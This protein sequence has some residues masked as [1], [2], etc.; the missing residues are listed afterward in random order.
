M[1][2]KNDGF[3]LIELMVVIALLGILAAAAIPSMKGWLA[4]YRLNDGVNQ[5][6]ASLSMA[7][8]TAIK[9]SINVRVVFSTGVG[10]SGT[11][12]VFTDDGG[13]TLANA[14]NGTWDAGERILVQGSMP[15][16][17]NLYSAAFGSTNAATTMFNPA[18]LPMQSASGALVY[19]AGSV[20]M[21]SNGNFRR[22]RIA[23]GGSVKIEKSL[24]ATGGAWFE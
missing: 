24:A 12:R 15:R 18:G 6:K 4:N 3:T 20:N 8:L 11:Y 23:Q 14:N 5:V 21:S 2:K 7:K 16:G 10:D 22:V 19:L 13:G 17:V 1:L 9:E